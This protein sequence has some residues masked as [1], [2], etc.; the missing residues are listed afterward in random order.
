MILPYIYLP[1]TLET[2]NN[3]IIFGAMQGGGRFF[4]YGEGRSQ[5]SWRNL[6]LG[7]QRKT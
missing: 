7:N 4:N 5:I 3:D 1:K 2:V 6:E